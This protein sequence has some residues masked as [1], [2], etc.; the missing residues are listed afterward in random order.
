[1]ME[2][3]SGNPRLQSLPH[4]DL[5]LVNGQGREDATGSNNASPL[6]EEDVGFDSVRYL[7]ANFGSLEIVSDSA[8]LHEICGQG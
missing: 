6:E 4:L 8:A 7:I 1:M 2:G 3:Q 5:Q